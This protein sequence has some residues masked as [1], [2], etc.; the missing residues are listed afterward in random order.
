MI[1][2]LSTI[3]QQVNNDHRLIRKAI[4]YIVLKEKFRIR[5]DVPTKVTF[6]VV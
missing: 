1:K 3:K 6:K 5:I 2:E 4:F